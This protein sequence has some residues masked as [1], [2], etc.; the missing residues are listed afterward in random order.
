MDLPLDS[1]TGT[2]SGA[3]FD[4][5]EPMPMSDLVRPARRRAAAAGGLVLAL[6][7]SAAPAALAQGGPEQVITDLMA[8]IEAKDFS[9]LGGF[10][11]AEHADQADAFDVSGMTAALPGVD[12][13]TILDAILLDTELTSLEVISQSDTEAIVRAEGSISTGMDPEKLGPFVEA[14]LAASGE[15]V[16][17]EMVEM[18]TGMLT[19]DMAPTVI[20][21]S[22]EVTVTPDG[23]GGW[24]ICDELGG[25]SASPEASMA[26]AA[27]AP[28][29][30]PTLAPEG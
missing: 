14:I 28:A 9:N 21:I 25:E 30:E 10:F 15:E 24:V 2:A 19:A 29:A 16:T 18:M 23:A 27:S 11:C 7:L 1:E 22:E 13:S 12:P 20:N 4:R 26:A 6:S 5:K 3:S 8:A 17:P